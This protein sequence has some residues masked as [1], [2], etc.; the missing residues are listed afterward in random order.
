MRTCSKCGQS[1]EDSGFRKSS[2]GKM[3]TDCLNLYFK[4]HYTTNAKYYVKKS[5]EAR[6]DLEKWYRELKDNKPCADCK[7]VHRY[8]ALDFDHRDSQT[9][10]ECVSNL[11]AIHSSKKKILTEISKCDLVCATCHRYRTQSRICTE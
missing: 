8:F 7:V 1:K 6:K 11:I 5:T 4:Q 2:R 9:K 10:E 3:C